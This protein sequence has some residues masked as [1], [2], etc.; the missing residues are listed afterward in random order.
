MMGPMTNLTRRD[1]LRGAG[2]SLVLGGAG[3][4]LFGG[5][6]GGDKDL[7]VRQETPYNAEP[8]LVPLA[9]SWTTPYPNFYIR[10]HGTV[11]DVDSVTYRLTIEGLVGRT[12]QFSLD[13]LNGMSKVTQPVTLTCAG[14]RR[15]EQHRVKAV[16]GVLWDVGAIGTP[17]WRGVR[18]AELLERVGVK[19][20]A[21]YVW[22]EGRDTVTLKDK[23]T[24]FGG[25]VP[26]EKALRAE[27][28]V[29]LEMNGRPLPREHGF[30][31]RTIIPGFIGARSVKW[32]HRIVVSDKPSDNNFVAR[33]YKMFPPEATPET[34]KPEQFEPIYENVINSAICSPRV[35]QVVR[36]GKLEVRGYALPSGAVGAGLSGVEVSADGG[37]TWVPARL[38]GKDV[39]FAWKLWTA[40]V[41]LATGERTLVVRAKDSKGAVQPEKSPWNFKGYL[42]NGWHRVP[43]TVS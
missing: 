36:P 27:S 4:S 38:Q 31:A 10:S 18:L 5:S 24:L 37:A 39:P 14:N 30:P 6:D 25:Q 7:N 17:E 15:A 34:V 32:L 29:A 33:D 19:A 13:D 9:E 22:F 42:Y 2:A 23:Q 43:I 8:N 35:G 11:P 28:M 16:G 41:Q 12:A 26:I 3:C 40:E 21:K 20:S 1:L